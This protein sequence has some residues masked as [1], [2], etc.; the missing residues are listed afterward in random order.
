MKNFDTAVLCCYWG[1]Q[2]HTRQVMEILLMTKYNTVVTTLQ[3][4]P[5]MGQA[6][7]S[8]NTERGQ[9]IVAFLQMKKLCNLVQ[10]LMDS[11]WNTRVLWCQSYVP[12]FHS[13]HLLSIEDIELWG[14][15]KTFPR[16]SAPEWSNLSGFATGMWPGL[17]WAM[18]RPVHRRAK[19]LFMLS[20]PSLWG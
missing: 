8:D 6:L 18:Y 1:N 5:S 20:F 10:S 9:S 4:V 19:W 15:R 2:H 7:N 3:S 13:T 11:N 12:F 17:R 16:P 14:H